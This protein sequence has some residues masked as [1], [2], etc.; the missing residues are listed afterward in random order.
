MADPVLFDLPPDLPPDLQAVGILTRSVEEL[1]SALADLARQHATLA[2]RVP[3]GRDGPTG[4]P[5]LL[6]W[7]DMDRDTASQVWMWLINWTEWF[8]NRYQ[9]QEELP[10]CWPQHPPLV[11]ELTGLCGAWHV[12]T[13]A[14]ASPD[15]L[16][17]WHEALARFRARIRE[18]DDQTKCRNG[19]HS[20]RHLD[21]TWTDDWRQRALET[22]AADV[23]GRP[24]AEPDA[25]IDA[26]PEPAAAG[27][28]GGKRP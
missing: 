13:D 24:V 20:D 8:V 28:S 18:W 2:R 5:G 19:R 1:R 6:R 23:A 17:R 9:L 14:D 7:R 21:L 4:V 3:A 22:A 12:T 10:A 27:A 26:E 25:A 11:E 15:A 16:L